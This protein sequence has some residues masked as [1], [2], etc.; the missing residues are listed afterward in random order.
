MNKTRETTQEEHEVL[1]YLN[2]LRDSGI[3]NMMGAV[4]FIQN[5]FGTDRNESRRLLTLW[6]ENYDE[7]GNYYQV[8][9]K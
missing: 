5:N 8:V 4:P 7:D 6:M 9:D 2:D 3:V 1:L